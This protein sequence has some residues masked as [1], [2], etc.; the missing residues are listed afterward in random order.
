MTLREGFTTGSCAAAA[1]RAAAEMLLCGREADAV[2][3]VTPAGKNFIAEVCDVRMEE[4]FVS[5]AVQKDS[6]DDPD[7]TNGVFIYAEVRRIG[8]PEILITG[9]EGVGRVTK[10]G[11][12]Q[13]VGEAAINSVP[14]RMIRQNLTELLE[15]YAVSGGFSVCIRIPEGR[16]LAEQTFNPRLGIVGGISVLGTTGIVK[17]MSEEALVE[18]IRT[19][20]RVKAAEGCEVLCAAPG[21]YG[22]HFL[23]SEYGFPEGQA[24][25][26]SN[27][28]YDTVC[29]AR[30][31]GFRKFL[32]VGHIGKLVKAAGGV[33]NTHSRYGDRRMEILAALSRPYLAGEDWKRCEKA[34]L[35]SVVTDDG[36]RILDEWG[37]REQV[38]RDMADQIRI[39]LNDWA[40][41]R[42][43]CQTIVFS[44]VYGILAGTELAEEYLMKAKG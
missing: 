26:A 7:I 44:N 20:I 34:L 31:A 2:T 19:E 3:I 11:L 16:R 27:Y 33:K 10:P 22:M 13:P 30:E 39:N 12:D 17:P 41:A 32:L 37:I 25:T 6:G 14:R 5:C 29:M 15:K 18:T 38:M 43:D 42:M 8:R 9:G 24:V 35:D 36:I 40:D 28:I 1:A 23:Q 4:G 21:N